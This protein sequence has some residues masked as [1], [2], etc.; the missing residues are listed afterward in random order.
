[1]TD[2]ADW[3]AS[4]IGAAP[5]ALPALTLQGASWIWSP[6]AT[7]Q[8]AP[9]GTRYFRG[10]LALPA[11]TSVAS[12]RVVATADDDFTLWL[13]GRETLHAPQKVDGWRSARAVD[14]ADQ[15]RA[16]V[17]AD[18]VLAAS[19]TNRPG[20]SVNPGGFIAKLLVTTSEG[21]EIVLVTDDAWRVADTAPTGWQAAGD[22]F[23]KQELLGQ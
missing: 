15:V 3:V 12:T 1:M 7:A 5:T 13:D 11:D 16:L 20:P 8:N 17:G 21:D 19:A 18:L 2:P 14:V 22:Y 6:G 4:W 9:A 10:R 23:T